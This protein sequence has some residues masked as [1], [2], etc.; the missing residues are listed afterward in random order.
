MRTNYMKLVGLLL[1]G[2]NLMAAN[3]GATNSVWNDAMLGICAI[4]AAMSILFL[5]L[6]YWGEREKKR[7]AEVALRESELRAGHILN[8][9][10]DAII[11]I[12]EDGLIESFN[13][14]AVTMF[15]CPA[16]DAVG[17]SI[18]KFLPAKDQRPAELYQHL[19]AA[20]PGQE[21]T[22]VRSDGSTFPVD[23]VT[24]EVSVSTK[25]MFSVFVR[26]VSTKNKAESA[27]ESERNFSAAVLD[28][29]GALIVVLDR[30]GRIVKFNRAC[31]ETTDYSFEE[32]KGRA[33]W[34][35]FAA[36]DRFD[37]M[38]RQT[39][40]M[41]Q[42]DFPAH[43]ENDW[44]IRDL[45]ARR[46]SWAHTAL[47]DKSGRVEHV[48][49]IGIDVTERRA[50]EEQLVHARKM[51]AIGRLAGGVAHDFNNL[52]TAITGY[53]DLILHSIRESDPIRRDVEEIKR[54][55][56][57]ATDL[58]RQLMA[59][60]RK[61]ILTPHVLNLNEVVSNTGRMLARL[62]GERIQVKL[63]LDEELNE[64]SA[65][66]SQLDQV[67][68]NLALNARD[69]M[70][71]GG[72][73]TIETANVSLGVSNTHADPAIGPGHYVT[74]RVID[75]GSGMSKETLTHIFEPFYTTKGPGQGTGLGLATVYGIVRQSNGVIDV[76]SALGRGSCFTI[77]F[78]VAG[79]GEEMP[80]VK[81]E[82]SRAL[83]GSE[84]ILLVEDDD[85]VRT[86]TTRVLERAGYH[87][88][89]ARNGVE[90]IDRSRQ[91]EGPIH[92]ML[93]DVE[94]PGMSGPDLAKLVG[95]ER[96]EM[97]TLFMSGHPL[98]YVEKHGIEFYLEKPVPMETLARTVR[99]VLDAPPIRAM[100]TTAGN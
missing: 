95:A 91:R 26:D 9:A 41:I 34:E 42:G 68:L 38:R 4:F 39:L 50:L 69:A 98:D 100:G 36:P 10:R 52:L 49:S 14:A 57:R 94:M 21:M 3:S 90:A 97:R 88:I 65:D 73:L 48:V 96:P 60:S 72:T 71:R 16:K 17:Q 12:N 83:E 99:D 5:L 75:T 33:I 15:G 85:E 8:G 27:L 25:R 23:L 92:L 20:S 70:P 6:F 24:D 32:I 87:V 74:L 7:L 81:D 54:A 13:P 80:A 84:T 40:E 35:I 93:S 59:F 30:D 44:R 53:S 82:L 45:T 11:S 66:A 89:G 43:S 19:K 76:S 29:A 61:Q 86:F 62:L 67:V 58:T 51:E 78:P 22:A 18:L 31:E 46:I 47:R 77:Y 63:V 56:D 1:T 79:S 28:T 55:G 37:A 2:G 64:I